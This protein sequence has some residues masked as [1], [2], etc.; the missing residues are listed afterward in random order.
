MKTNKLSALELFRNEEAKLAAIELSSSQY[1]CWNDDLI[2]KYHDFIDWDLLSGNLNLRWSKELIMR[3]EEQWEWRALSYVVANIIEEA[4]FRQILCIFKER[5]S[6]SIICQGV[7]ITPQ[8]VKDYPEHIHWEALSSN[9]LFNWSEGFVEKHRKQIDWD[10][11]SSILSKNTFRKR[12]EISM[13]GD[14]PKNINS[15]GNDF[16]ARYADLWNWDNLSENS[17]FIFQKDFLQAF[18]DQWNWKLLI[19]NESVVW[20]FDLLEEFNPELSTL[21]EA[22]LKESC[23]WQRMHKVAGDRFRNKDLEFILALF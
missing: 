17:L 19:N 23:F 9:N 22:E 13:P 4:E 11:F 7:N 3:Y 6:W 1:T 20:S 12:S 5:L 8:I 2:R 18:R 14:E 21:S 10:A 15:F 16:V